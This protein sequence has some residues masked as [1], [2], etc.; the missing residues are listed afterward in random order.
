[1]E[2]RF[3]KSKVLRL[4]GGLLIFVSAQMTGEASNFQDRWT[5]NLLS[6]DAAKA[7]QAVLKLF[8]GGAHV[9]PDLTKIAASTKIFHG[10]FPFD[11]SESQIRSE[12]PTV[13]VVG[14]YLIERRKGERGQI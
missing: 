13:G 9:L 4:C 12:R 2:A 6:G 5:A 3:D 11:D 14:M 8:Q 1:M 7:D 10:Q